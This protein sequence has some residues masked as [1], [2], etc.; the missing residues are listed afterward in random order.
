V[1]RKEDMT[2]FRVIT[3]YTYEK[4]SILLH[5]THILT[6]LI[7]RWIQVEMSEYQRN[8]K[9]DQEYV[10]QSAYPKG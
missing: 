5:E 10:Q 4:I 9:R 7:V 1:L 6:G 3:K 2:F 8:D